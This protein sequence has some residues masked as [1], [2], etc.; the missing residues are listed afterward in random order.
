MIGV[1]FFCVLAVISA[2]SNT[3]TIAY[4]RPLTDFFAWV[5]D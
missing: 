2:R 1:G 3:F 4:Y 5:Q